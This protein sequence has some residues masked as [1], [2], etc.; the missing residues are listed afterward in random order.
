MLESD[1][2]LP[3]PQPSTALVYNHLRAILQSINELH[4]LEAVMNNEGFTAGVGQLEV[5]GR[6]LYSVILTMA[7]REPLVSLKSALSLV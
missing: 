3:L 6:R 4:R 7:A 5:S 1:S 2:S